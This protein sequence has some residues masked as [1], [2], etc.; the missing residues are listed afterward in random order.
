M[1]E[2]EMMDF[3]LQPDGRLT[4]WEME[5]G[6][7]FALDST[8][9]F[10]DRFHA[11]PGYWCDDHELQVLPNGEYYIIVSDEQVMDLT[12]YGGQPDAEVIGNHVA[13]MD[14]DDNPI[15]I[16]RSWDHLDEM[17]VIDGVGGEND[18]DDNWID[19][20]HMNAID[21]DLDGNIVVSNRH[22]SEITK[23]NRQTGDIMWRLGGKKDYFTWINDDDRIS[24]QHSIRVL[25][26]GNYTIFDN[27]NFHDPHFSRALE[28]EL[29][30]VNWTAKKIWDFRDSP[31]V[32]SWAMGNVQRLENGNTL[33]NW[34][35][36]NP[37][38]TEVRPNGEKSFE[39]SIYPHPAVYRA[40]K[41]DW[42]GKARVPNL[43]IEPQADNITLLF[44]K[45]G[46]YEVDSY[47]IYGGQQPSPTEILATSTEPYIQLSDLENQRTYYFRVTAVNVSGVESDFSDQKQIYVSIVPAGTNLVVNGDF[48][49]GIFEWNWELDDDAQATWEIT[50]DNEF[51]FNIT[52]SGSNLADIQLIQPGVSLVKG[53][54][55]LL[56]FDARAINSPRVIEVEVKNGFWPN[57]NYSRRGL[58]F[59]QTEMRRFS[60]EF[61]MEEQSDSNAEIVINVGGS[62]ISVIVDNIS[63]K[64]PVT[65]VEDKKGGIP[66]KYHLENN[67]PNP[68]N[69]KTIINY[70]LPITNDVDLS[71]YNMLGQ[72]VAT[73]FSEKKN[74]GYHQVEW[75]ATDYAS[76]I[77]YYRIQA[78]DFH[79]VKKMILIR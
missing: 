14:A 70:E 69:P 46:D 64:I 43:N 28:L 59:I 41:I 33:I 67:Y 54:K 63:L 61:E 37:V 32:E 40:F 2:H 1:K 17:E 4:A 57:N 39:A 35:L 21:F 38:I 3:K 49:E 77:Y 10:V 53:E 75:D 76:G 66:L 27:G 42:E 9:T 19:Y 55:Y 34:S 5:P 51:Q 15:W 50:Q 72:K 12:A 79:D 36:E 11:P 31:D 26:N 22:M 71:I 52:T 62:D 8:Y 25:P 24:Y 58:T 18:I 74:A 13:H 7:P 16:W 56:E 47:N 78:G 48:S 68:F 6:C 65:S 44:N 29:D 20:M 45:F 60:H 73:L 30:T 23:I